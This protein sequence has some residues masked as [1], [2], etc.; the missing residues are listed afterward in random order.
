MELAEGSD[1]ILLSEGGV[2]G[3]GL[4]EVVLRGT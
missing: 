4:G 2:E 1:G 3:W